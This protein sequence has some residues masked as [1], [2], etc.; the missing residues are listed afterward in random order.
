MRG[1]QLKTS[2]FFG[3]NRGHQGVVTCMCL[4]GCWKGSIRQT[5]NSTHSAHHIYFMKSS[6]AH[7][8]SERPSPLWFF[9]IPDFPHRHWAINGLR[10]DSK[11]IQMLFG[12]RAFWRNYQAQLMSDSLLLE[13]NDGPNRHN[14]PEQAWVQFVVTGRY[15]RR[16]VIILSLKNCYWNSN[17][18]QTF[19]QLKQGNG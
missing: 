18:V 8:G 5:H 10:T 12:G 17:H 13:T 15:Y 14:K 3:V 4:A 1:H 19:L 2:L 11:L 16:V 6:S 9:S 7:S